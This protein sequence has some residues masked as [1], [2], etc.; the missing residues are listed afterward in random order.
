MDNKKKKKSKI[1][2]EIRQE[3]KLK[4]QAADLHLQEINNLKEKLN[5]NINKVVILGVCSPVLAYEAYKQNTDVA[6][7]IPCNL[8][9]TEKSPTECSLEFTKPSQMIHF[10]ENIKMQSTIEKAEADI[11]KIFSKL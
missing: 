8:V 10:I 4:A 2:E 6:L 1:E 5:Q 3:S 9:I 11:E 7:L